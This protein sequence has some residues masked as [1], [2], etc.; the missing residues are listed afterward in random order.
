[1]VNKHKHLDAA[2]RRWLKE[3]LERRCDPQ[4]LTQILS[5]N[6]FSPE[7]I[8][9][10]MSAAVVTNTAGDTSSDANHSVPERAADSSWQHWLKENLERGCDP[11]ELLVT[12]LE[13]NFSEQSIMQMI[14]KINAGS[15]DTAHAQSAAACDYAAIAAPPLLGRNL[16]QLQEAATDA[17]QL[18]T[19][20]A[21]LSD[22][23]CDAIVAIANRHLRPS[24]V[25]IGDDKYYRTSR[26]CD[27]SLLNDPV[28][29]ALDLKIA[30]MLGIRPEYAEGTQAQRYDVGEEFKQH[31]DYFEPHTS[32]YERFAAERG[33]RTWTLMVYL[34]DDMQGGGTRFFAIDRTFQPKKG[35]AVLWNNLRPDGSPNADTLHS[36]EPVVAGHKIIITKWFREQGSGAMFFD[37]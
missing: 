19:F 29:S 15:D 18:Y 11:Q 30:T 10:A 31:T 2:W 35:M 26:T 32:E 5:R 24:T 3:N 22:E 25:T 36:G 6:G 7:A 4:E 27:L 37:A 28:V 33:N 12:L 34:N 8:Q 14:G 21:F 9:Q 1:M 16:P 20:D 23:E 13:H 17:L